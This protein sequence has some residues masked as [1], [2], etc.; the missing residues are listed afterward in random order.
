[1]IENVRTLVG[2]VHILSGDNRGEEK[3]LKQST[4]EKATL[5][6]NKS[7]EDKLQY[8]KQLQT[9][10]KKVIM[11]GDGLNDA[12]ALQ[13]SDIGLA[14]ADNSNYF[15]P[16]CD[17]ILDGNSVTQMDKLIELARSGKSIIAAGFTLSILYN[18]VGISYAAQGAL[19]PM[20]A[21]ILMP[22][23]TISI[24]VLTAIGTRW[25]AKK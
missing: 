20:I 7:P 14:V 15:T 1:M 12:G 22:A 11:I 18:F 9:E 10:G 6:F 17:G 16:A 24:I 19:S 21:A 23:S 25:A 8:I 13:Q 3:F 5:N 4:Q 2:K